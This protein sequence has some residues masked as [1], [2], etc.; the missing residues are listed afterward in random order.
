MQPPAGGNSEHSTADIL[1]GVPYGQSLEE[2]E[3]YKREG[4][5]P[6]QHGGDSDGGGKGGA[7]LENN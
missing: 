4:K 2:R 5:F 3:R 6:L 1:P 7:M